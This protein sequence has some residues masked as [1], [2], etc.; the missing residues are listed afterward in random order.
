MPRLDISLIGHIITTLSFIGVAAYAFYRE[1]DLYRTTQKPPFLFF[2]IIGISLLFAILNMFRI[3]YEITGGSETTLSTDADLIAQFSSIFVQS[4]LILI[5]FA[6]K[7]IIQPRSKAGRV[8]AIGAH[9]DDIEI[10]AGAALASAPRLEST[11]RFAT[12]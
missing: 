10:A 11:S 3:F 7:I 1:R 8:L 4:A 2:V 12:R 9:P 6:N 5:L